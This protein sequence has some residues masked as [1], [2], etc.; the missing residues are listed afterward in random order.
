MFISN[1]LQDV[2]KYQAKQL[3]VIE[4]LM[5]TKGKNR[6]LRIYD[7]TIAINFPSILQSLV[8]IITFQA[9]TNQT[10]FHWAYAAEE[11]DRDLRISPGTIMLS[12]A[13]AAALYLIFYTVM[14]RFSEREYF[15]VNTKVAYVLFTFVL[16]AALNRTG[17]I[18]A[19]V[20]GEDYSS[21]T[22][23]LAE[24]QWVLGLFIFVMVVL[25]GFVYPLYTRLG[26]CGRCKPSKEEL[27]NTDHL[28]DAPQKE[29]LPAE[30]IQRLNIRVAGVQSQL[31]SIR[32][33]QVPLSL[34]Q[35][36]STPL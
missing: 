10:K 26:C 22:D 8:S 4:V 33:E 34:T 29:T 28:T 21:L 15:N 1:P 18:E 17:N 9:Y 20:E 32:E 5:D 14:D 7:H 19:P 23:W 12:T 11:I 6:L 2:I 35:Q 25:Y 27:E 24:G 16:L 30:M 31:D 3:G 13:L 36:L